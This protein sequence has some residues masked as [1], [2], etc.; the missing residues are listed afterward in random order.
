VFKQ[1]EQ[2]S[3]K[4]EHTKAAAAFLRAARE[5]PREPRAAQA[6]VNAEVEA[7]HGGDFE[8]MRT[9]ADLLVQSHSG[10]EEAAQGVWIA[11]AAYQ[12]VGLFSE[13]AGYHEVLAEKW[14]KYEHAKDAAYNAVLLRTTVGEHDRAIADGNAYKRKYPRGDDADEV[15]FLMG[16]AHEKAE[17]WRDAE[18]LYSSYS[19][20]AKSSS[21]RIEALVRL[22]T[23]KLRLGDERGADGALDRAMQAHRT[24]K[25]SLDDNGKYFAA[26]AHYMQGERTLAEFERIKIEGDVGQL[27]SRLKKKSDL[28]K[29][30]ADTFLETAEMGVAEWTTASLYQIGVTYESFSKSLLNSPPPP[31]LS[32]EQKELYQQQIE[33]FVIPIEEKGLEAYESG[34]QKAIE[35]GIMNQWTAK[36]REA[37]GRLNTELYPPLHEIGFEVRSRSVSPLPPLIDAPRRSSD[38]R[39]TPYLVP[40]KRSAEPAKTPG[41]TPASTK[42]GGPG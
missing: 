21:S 17:K 37:L 38:G 16:K 14:P 33:E 39:S 15:T 35:L 23:V 22:A 31:S 1:G 25:K 34:W 27:K 18:A 2:L 19:Q 41:T 24:Y 20:T 3:Q 36:M 5:F 30:A 11:A 42:T 13:S 7:K 10:R 40:S 29:R 28:L 12:S 8:T 4:G 26:K 6:A 9:A 32:A